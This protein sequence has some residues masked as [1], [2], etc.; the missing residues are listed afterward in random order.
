MF[1]GLKNIIQGVISKVLNRTTIQKE[2]DVDISVS[3][4]M[5]QAIDLWSMIYKNQAPWLDKNTSSLNLGAS[6]ANEFARLVTLELESE[7]VGNDYLQEQYKRV[8]DEIRKYTEYACAKGGLVFKPYVDGDIIAVDTVQADNFFPCGFNSRGDI[9]S[10]IFVERVTKGKYIY[11]RLEHHSLEDNNT[12]V[13]TNKAY[14]NKS[15]MLNYDNNYSLGEQV[16]LTAVDEWKDLQEEATINNVEK[17]LFSYF[18]VPG[19]NN[20][21]TSSPLGVSCYARAVDAIKEADKQYSRI[22]WEFEGSELAVN[23][24]VDAFKLD[25]KGNA[26]L[27]K[28]HERLYRAFDFASNESNKIMD[29]FSPEIRDTNLF[30]GLNQLLRRIEFLCGLAYGSISDINETDKTATEIKASKQRSYSTVKDIQNALETALKN[31][32]YAINVWAVLAGKSKS[33]KYEMTFNW[34]DSLIM[35]KESDLLSMQQDVA[36]GLIRPELYIMKKYG[37]TEEEA[38]KMMPNDLTEEDKFEKG[39][40]PNTGLPSEGDK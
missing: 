21:D 2:M 10:A 39:N 29:T 28:G 35:D 24:S 37:V 40:D 22:L 36:S 18:K 7:V 16:P 15:G 8:V 25:N 6:I 14:M 31:L 30:N 1:E 11:T 32:V 17:P 9:T 33:L 4:V 20:I 12:Y 26:I 34:D 38:K 3:D 19:A 27:P 5:G 13:I 23:A